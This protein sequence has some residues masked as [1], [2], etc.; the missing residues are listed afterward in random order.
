MRWLRNSLI[1]VALV[2]GVVFIGSTNASAAGTGVSRTSQQI[3]ANVDS[4]AD[5]RWEW[6]GQFA[7][8]PTCNLEGIF[9]ITFTSADD[10]LCAPP[11]PGQVKWNLWLFYDD[12]GCSVSAL[13]VGSTRPE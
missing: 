6:G 7:T 2:A 10:Y 9:R 1:A 12:C 13:E 3:A 4:A 8:Q 5:G 11:G